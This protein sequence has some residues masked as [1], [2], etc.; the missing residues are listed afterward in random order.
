MNKT[1][2]DI[3]SAR[4]FLLNIISDLSVD[5]LNK[6]PAGFN[7]NIIWN[8]AHMIAA[9]QGVCYMRAGKPIVVEEKY[10]AEY[11]PGTKP[12]QQVDK[13]EVQKIKDLLF[14]TL[15]HLAADYET[16]MFENYKTWTTRYGAELAS[17]NDAI[18]FLLYHEGLH[19]GVILAIKKLV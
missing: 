10:F 2:N 19:S 11:K 16:N 4:L 17:I 12:E 7:N 1:I 14:T 15:D 6:I 8:L 5:Q 13:A 18:S 9:Q 3:K